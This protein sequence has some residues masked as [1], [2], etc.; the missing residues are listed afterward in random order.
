MFVP[1]GCW[2]LPTVCRWSLLRVTLWLSRCERCSGPRTAPQHLLGPLGTRR[3]AEHRHA[4]LRVVRSSRGIKMDSEGGLQAPIN[5]KRGLE[6]SWVQHRD[7]RPK[8]EHRAATLPAP[9]AQAV[10]QLS[11]LC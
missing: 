9:L 10:L 5:L 7:W 11:A 3:T 2:T 8:G 6:S 4:R 1:L